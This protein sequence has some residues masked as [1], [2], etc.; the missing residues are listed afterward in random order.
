MDDE[1]EECDGNFW[2]AGA[3]P[4]A[5]SKGRRFEERRT[6]AEGNGRGRDSAGSPL[7]TGMAVFLSSHIL[8]AAKSLVLGVSLV[9]SEITGGSPLPARQRPSP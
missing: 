4:S 7:D 1:E 8:S 3:I 5:E 6:N 2:G 9:Y